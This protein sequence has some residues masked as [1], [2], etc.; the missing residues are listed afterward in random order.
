M[1]ISE[2]FASM[3]GEGPDMGKIVTFVRLAGC[4]LS[5]DFCD[6]K[7]ALTQ[8]MEIAKEEVLQTILRMSP[9]SVVFT[10]GEPALQMEEVAWVV[11]Q[12][13]EVGY[14]TAIE[15]NGTI[16][17]DPRI[18]DVV[19]ISP[20]TE[21]AIVDWVPINKMGL[22]HIKFVVDENNIESVMLSCREHDIISPYFMPKGTT[23][24]EMYYGTK[25]IIDKMLENGIQGFASPRLHVLV[26]AK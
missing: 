21:N 26:G 13:K 12:L 8:F 11:T 9:N 16:T 19:V 10:G 20:K 24:E 6:T 5:C 22:A 25:M 15:S 18:F 7:Y 4:N 14:H 17:F 3:Q 1:K 2:I 23:F